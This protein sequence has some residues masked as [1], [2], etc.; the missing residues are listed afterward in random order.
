MSCE[1]PLQNNFTNFDS[2]SV[3]W[4]RAYFPYLTIF[5]SGYWTQL[6]LYWILSTFSDEV[7]DASRS[8][9]VFRAFEV[10]GQAVSYGL[11]SAKSI[12]HAIP[13][14]INVALLVFTIPTM[15][16]LINKMPRGPR[17]L[18]NPDD[19]DNKI[20]FVFEE[21]EPAKTK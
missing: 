9:G 15:S 4:F 16:M 5:V 7:T 18:A 11:S 10:A 13:L 19:D 21:L 2:E 1:L 6:T 17:R 14:Y 3:K 12:D 20:D 8:G